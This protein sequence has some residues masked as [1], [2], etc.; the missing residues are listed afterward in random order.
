M[1][2]GKSPKTTY[3]CTLICGLISVFASATV[4]KDDFKSYP[5]YDPAISGWTF[6]TIGGEVIDGKFMFNVPLS[7][8][9]A[10]VRDFDAGPNLKIIAKLKRCPHKFDFFNR[11]GENG[12]LGII[13][14]GDKLRPGVKAEKNIPICTLSL[15]GMAGGSGEFR[16][17]YDGIPKIESKVKVI[18]KGQRWQENKEYTLELKLV[19]NILTGTV[20]DD[21]RKIVYQAEI[22]NPELSKAFATAYPGFI[23][24]KATGELASFEADNL[25]SHP[26]NQTVKLIDFPLSEYWTTSLADKKVKFEPGIYYDFNKLSGEKHIPGQTITLTSKLKVPD[27][28]IAFNSCRADWFWNLKVNA[29]LIADHMTNSNGSRLETILIP[30]K[31]GMNT[32]E[33]TVVSGEKGWKFCFSNMS[34]EGAKKV[35]SKEYVRGSNVL[36]WNVERL[37]DDVANLKRN[38]IELDKMKNKLVDLQTHAPANLGFQDIKAYDKLLDNAYASV[39]DGYRYVELLNAIQ[40]F[41]AYGLD[42][43]KLTELKEISKKLKQQINSEEEI[44]G[45]AKNAQRLIDEIKP[46]MDGFAEGVTRGGSFG[47]FGWVTSNTLGVYSSGDGLLANQVLSSGAIARQYVTAADNQRVPYCVN[48]EFDGELDNSFGDKIFSQTTA[49]ANV[50][51][52]LGYMPKMSYSGKTPDEVKVKEINWIHKKFSYNNKFVADI[53]LLSPAVLL[54]SPYKKFQLSDPATG[55][56]TNFGYKTCN[57]EIIS[58]TISGNDILYDKKKDGA[59]GANWIMFWNG[60]NTEVDLAGH[61]GNIPMQVIFQRQPQKITRNN[62]K[63]TIAF[64]DAGAIWLNTPYG[65]RIQPTINWNGLLPPEA[66]MK[67]DLFAKTALAYPVDCRE[68]YRY[69]PDKKELE[70]LN[71]YSYRLFEDNDWNIKPVKIAL[72]PPALSLMTDNGFDAILPSKLYDLDYP[73][74]YGP[75]RGVFD[76]K[77]TYTLPVQDIPSVI[78]GKNIEADP[79]AVNSIL[80]QTI[81]RIHGVRSF[82]LEERGSYDWHSLQL[83]IGI[84]KQWFYLPSSYREY[85]NRLNESNLKFAANYREHRIWR[86]LVEPYSGKKYFYSFSIQSGSPD[87]VGIA[88]DRGYG[89]GQ[90]LWNMDRVIEYSGNYELLRKMWSDPNPLAPSC[91]VKDG[92]SLSVDKMFGYLK[93]V[94][95][96]AWMFSGSNDSGDNGPVVDCAQATFA[97]HA[98]YLRMAEKVGN[99]EEISRGAYYQAKSQVGLMGR[100]V[101]DNYGIENGLL[102]VDSINVG[103]RECITPDCFANYSRFKNAY[104]GSFVADLSY[105]SN[106]D[107]FDIYFPYARYIWKDL[108]RCNRNNQLYFPNFDIEKKNQIQLISYL[109]FLALNGEALDQLNQIYHNIVGKSHYQGDLRTLPVIISGGNPMVLANWYPLE[110]PYFE[111]SPSEKKAVIKFKTVPRNY[112]LHA[113]SSSRPLSVKVDEK[114]LIWTY[115][116]E[117]Y[118]F[119]I[120]VPA[121][122]DITVVIFYD[123]IDTNRFTPIPI[124][125]SKKLIPEMQDQV[126]YLNRQR[127]IAS[128]VRNTKTTNTQLENGKLLFRSEFDKESENNVKVSG[129][130]QFRNWGGSKVEP[131]G[132]VTGPFPKGPI[133]PSAMEIN[134]STN[135][136]SGRS[137]HDINLPKSFSD[138]RLSG[139]VMRS[140]EYNGNIPMI[141]IWF[142]D[143]NKQGKPVFIK[144]PS[145]DNNKWQLFSVKITKQKIPQHAISLSINLTSCKPK[146]ATDVSGSVYY[147]DIVLTAD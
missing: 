16:L 79:K 143:K 67:A 129:G 42:N 7:L 123:K 141:L 88:G 105:S 21:S 92:G 2:K 75:L 98:A 124:A 112:S 48:F 142:E 46:E 5:D 87:D 103:F 120:E 113:L 95:D 43:D 30:L 15:E 146:E 89:V 121:G 94:H 114:E 76:S 119:D 125:A 109:Q 17:K 110:L 71:K 36:Y 4:F 106:D 72:L 144:I 45:T 23:S 24:Y 12:L 96:W 78:I 131:S 6:Q 139:K 145:E 64:A 41:K 126:N 100:I 108:Q 3:V 136:L 140:A 22:A 38:G 53:S 8:T 39:Y 1:L 58:G 44:E 62:N 68:F 122:K 83:F 40:E 51:L 104:Y 57:G 84:M 18:T 93:N 54:E 128:T 102:G 52:E 66:I 63:I 116:H 10:I 90:H 86:S 11:N 111:F 20:S 73:T 13:I 99:A 97:G 60:N 28:C 133:P 118:K 81:P 37:L 9:T 74:L 56:F 65:A 80:C 70:I 127:G 132:G 138:L 82:T 69:H 26:K 32:I 59:F 85:L 27:D 61:R 14:R 134:A 130:F 19:N 147:K 77:I 135:G 50:E 47:R 101:F 25:N 31:A 91:A 107:G 35:L 49:G 137:S 55:A 34:R 117:S 115:D 29:K 33:L